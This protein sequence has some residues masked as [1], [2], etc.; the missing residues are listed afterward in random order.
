[1][2]AMPLAFGNEGGGNCPRAA[3]WRAASSPAMR[4]NIVPMVMPMPAR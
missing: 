4:P 2:L 1:M 3:T